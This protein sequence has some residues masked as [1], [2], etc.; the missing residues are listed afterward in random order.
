[1][2]IICPRCQIQF[3]VANHS[4]DVVHNCNSGNNV[5]DQE[6]VLIKGPWTDF[7]GSDFTQ[8]T[9]ASS[10]ENQNLGNKLMGTR[11]WVEDNEKLPEFTVRGNN[12]FITRQRPHLE[13]IPDVQNAPKATSYRVDTSI[14]GK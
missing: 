11:P 1:M 6:D 7:T 10:V 4:G 5:L 8:R 2:M 3:S 9:S 12:A 13:Y 14:I